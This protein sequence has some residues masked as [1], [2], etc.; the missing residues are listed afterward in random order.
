MVDGWSELRPGCEWM[1]RVC[2]LHQTYRSSAGEGERMRKGTERKRQG[3]CCIIRCVAPGYL[4]LGCTNCAIR[5][6]KKPTY[7]RD[8]PLPR[9]QRATDSLFLSTMAELRIWIGS[10]EMDYGRPVLPPGREVTSFC[11][12]VVQRPGRRVRQ[13]N[14]TGEIARCRGLLINRLGTPSGRVSRLRGL[15]V[16]NVR[17][18]ICP[19][20]GVP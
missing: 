19:I 18:P 11:L 2:D 7:D 6:R 8:D 1:A 13:G 4:A 20:H 12:L 14:L 16:I 10:A 3:W 9:T 15:I 17:C 5:E